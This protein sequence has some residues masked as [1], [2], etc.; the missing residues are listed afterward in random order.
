[1]FNGR[2]LGLGLGITEL[3]PFT[4][5]EVPTHVEVDGLHTILST[6]SQI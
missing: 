6:P 3:Y 4:I 1:M 2:K 5:Y